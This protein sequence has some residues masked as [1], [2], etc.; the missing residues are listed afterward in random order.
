MS[1]PRSSSNSG[2]APSRSAI[3][4]IARPS[5]SVGIPVSSWKA[6]KES[7][8]G[9]VRTPPKSEITAR[10]ATRRAVD[11]TGDSSPAGRRPGDP[12]IDPIRGRQRNGG[13]RGKGRHGSAP[14]LL[15]RHFLG[16][17]PQVKAAPER[18]A[19]KMRKSRHRRLAVVVAA[20]AAAAI[21]VPLG[22]GSSH[23]EAPNIALDPAADNTDVYAFTAKDAPNALTIA[24][25]WIPGQVPA[26]GPN[27]F[28]F[29]D[30]A[31]VLR[32]HRQHRR[33]RCRH[34]VPVQVQDQRPEP[35]L[36]PLR[37]SGDRR[38]STIP[39]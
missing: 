19:R 20:V 10:I 35:E 17:A 8:S 1:F 12:A 9:V 11:Q 3:R 24:A 29:D 23:R 37:G 34:Q 33:R 2:W 14:A 36:L 28:R 38:T 21:A 7:S 4:C 5:A 22:F 32:E 26:N 18:G 13:I 27:F 15:D 31:Q 6:A 25:D 16:P 30:R 39:A